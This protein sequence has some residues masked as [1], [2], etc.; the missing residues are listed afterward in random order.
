MQLYLCTAT[1]AP[2]VGCLSRASGNISCQGKEP[3]AFKKLGKA[4]KVEELPDIPETS[5]EEDDNKTCNKAKAKNLS[6]AQQDP[7]I[8]T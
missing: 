4:K 6:D 8:R 3:V 2:P 1:A 7:P 5:E